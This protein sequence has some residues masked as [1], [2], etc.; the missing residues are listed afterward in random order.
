VT[1]RLGMGRSLDEVQQLVRRF[2]GPAAVHQALADVHAHWK[3]LLGAVQVRT[4]DPALDLLANGWLVYQTLG[5]R[6]MAR[7]G[8]YQS[9]GA[10]GFRDQLQDAMALVHARPQVLRDHLLL[11]AG[12][13]FQQ[14]DVQHWWH[15]PWGHGVRTHI[16]D[17]YLWLPLALCRYVEATNDTGV[18]DEN[19]AFLEG[20]PLPLEQE[21]WYDLPARSGRG[22]SV[23]AHAA[24][25][26]EHGLKFGAHGLPLMA[27]GDWNDGMNRVGHHGQGE[28]VWLG[29]FLCEVLRQFAPLAR[30]RGDHALAQRCESER[31]AL[32]DR[33]EREAWDGQW[34][35]RAWFDDGTPLGTHA[36]AECRI[37]S[38]AQSWSVLAG[39]TDTPRTREAM[40]SLATHLVRPE[41]MLVQ[42]LDPPFDRRGPDPG[43]IAGYLPGVRENGGQYTH[44]A[45]WAAMAFAALGDAPR[46]WQLMDM[47]NPL[48]HGRTAQEVAVYQVEPYVVAADVY[49][50]PPHT[51]RGG[52]SWYTGSA[53]WMYRLV[54]ESL[55]G[56]HLRIDDEGA[57][58]DIVP[59]V[60]AQWD[61]YAVDYCFRH[62]MYQLEIVLSADAAD[63]TPLELDGVAQ[64]PGAL[65]LVDDGRTHR[66]R[67]HRRPSGRS[68]DAPPQPA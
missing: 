33:L 38:I 47:I 9:G 29:F 55:L 67:V 22:A 16:S 34:Y 43:Y 44:A 35:R 19:A 24:L 50:M 53:G 10:F 48:N 8:H 11:C 42:L 31:L 13:Q 15:P 41:A 2:R 36:G 52:W 64:P 60:P 49:S 57:W 59:C 25:A 6:M 12:R 62:T 3:H 54:V 26:I 17:D 66:V 68:M 63:A 18:L 30:R 4:P 20:R 5:C 39:A 14:G 45:V 51:G 21:S 46:A 40:D 23:Y 1:F 56:L 58:L 7:S 37:D 65:A 61:G 32:R 27:G 28:S